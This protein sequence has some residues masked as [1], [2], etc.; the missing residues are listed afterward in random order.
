MEPHESLERASGAGLSRL[1]RVEASQRQAQRNHAWKRSRRR[2]RAHMLQL[3]GS[4]WVPLWL[5]RGT[6]RAALPLVRRLDLRARRVLRA[7]LVLVQSAAGVA[8]A[9]ALEGR[10]L[11]HAIEQFTNWVRLSRTRHPNDPRTAWILDEVRC[12]PAAEA[13]VAR[14]VAGQPAIIATAHLGDWELLAAYLARRGVRGGVVVLDRREDPTSAWLTG[15]RTRNGVPTHAHDAPPRQLLRALAQGQVVGL[16]TDLETP[17]SEQLTLPFLGVPALCAV[18]PAGLARLSGVPIVP[19]VCVRTRP[20]EQTGATWRVEATES[21][22]WTQSE[23][24]AQESERVLRA[25]NAVYEGWIR[26]WPEQW[27]W[28]QPR[29]RGAMKAR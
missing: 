21:I 15:L 18:A 4:Q 1:R 13:V 22:T 3:L 24:P 11:A 10:V 23:A 20:D 17:R 12:S 25:L 26:R 29:W 8:D 19:L 6:L 14:L 28:H 16:L 5:V 27:A 9:H 2:L 7:N